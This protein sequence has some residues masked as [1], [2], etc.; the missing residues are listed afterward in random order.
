[1]VEN[2]RLTI[3][4]TDHQQLKSFA[5]AQMGRF[6][7]KGLLTSEEHTHFKERGWGVDFSGWLGGISPGNGKKYM[8]IG[9]E[10]HIVHPQLVQVVYDFF[11]KKGMEDSE[12][13]QELYL[14]GHPLWKRV[15]ELIYDDP[16]NKA[17][18][19]LDCYIADICHF[20]PFNIGSADTIKQKVSRWNKIRAVAAERYLLEEIQAL[21]P[22]VIIAQG[23]TAFHTLKSLFGIRNG[24]VQILNKYAVGP[25][26][27]AIVR[28]FQ[29]PDRVVI[30][31][32]HMGTSFNINRKFWNEHTAKVR[33][34]LLNKGLLPI[35]S[36]TI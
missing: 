35:A 28:Y 36:L 32:P 16:Q 1:M 11:S 10:P 13:A 31:V 26:K 22:S 27:I 17:E 14:T 18:A 30:G 20:A 15:S 5:A 3:P 29:L 9:V 6:I 12:R 19:L 8:I 25:R 4:N 2:G 24:S 34:D 33:E 21:S 7:E 23:H